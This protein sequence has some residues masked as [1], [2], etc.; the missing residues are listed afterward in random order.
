MNESV[1]YSK[2]TNMNFGEALQAL[3]DG[4]TVKRAIWGGRWYLAK[5]A[6]LNGPSPIGGGYT[7]SCQFNQIIVAELKDMGGVA[8]AQPYQADILAEDWQIVE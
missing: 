2:T 5:D 3:K 6:V 7:M 4:K 1:Q 8:P